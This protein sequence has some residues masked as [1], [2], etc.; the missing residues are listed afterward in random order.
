MRG[1]PVLGVIF[2]L[3]FGV[4][5]ALLLQQFSIRPLDNLSVF[6]FPILGL[7]IGLA[8]AKWAPFSRR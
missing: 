7:L 3:L 2:G 8:L 4:F 6:G 5:F 1:R